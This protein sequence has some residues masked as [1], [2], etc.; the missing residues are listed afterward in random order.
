[1]NQRKTESCK[2]K[3]SKI[4]VVSDQ[5]DPDLT[6]PQTPVKMPGNRDEEKTHYWSLRDIPKFE[7]KGEQPFSHLMEF[8][9]NLIA[10][11]VRME[12]DEDEDGRRVDVD[13]RDIINK[14][15]ASLKNNARVWYNMYI[16]G[17]ITDLCS[18][19]GWK[20]IKSR[21]LTYFNPI[22]NTK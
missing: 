20:T 11:G 3:P 19:A 10:S 22:G 8:E 2:Q 1:M 16:D 13:Y 15:K 21:F 17:R 6:P 18:E 4:S 5:Q 14:F 7:G 12:P 9:D